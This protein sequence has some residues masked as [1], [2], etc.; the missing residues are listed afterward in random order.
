MRDCIK[1][2]GERAR[3][4]SLAL[5]PTKSNSETKTEA[6]QTIMSKQLCTHINVAGQQATAFS[7]SRNL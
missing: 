5:F 4:L 1:A 7:L 6:R 2:G 3:N